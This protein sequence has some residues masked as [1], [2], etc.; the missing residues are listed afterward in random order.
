MEKSGHWGLPYRTAGG[1]SG[2]YCR[3]KRSVFLHL[4]AAR[5]I[6]WKE[7]RSEEPRAWQLSPHSSTSSPSPSLILSTLAQVLEERGHGGRTF[8]RLSSERLLG[9]A[10]SLSFAQRSGDP[11]AFRDSLFTPPQGRRAH[12]AQE[13]ATPAIG[14][15]TDGAVGPA[16]APGGLGEPSLRASRFSRGAALLP[17]KAKLRSRQQREPAACRSR[18]GCDSGNLEAVV[19]RPEALGHTGNTV[20]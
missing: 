6:Q 17:S 2:T 18:S 5:V 15:D 7:A 19:A 12:R 11:S 8:C 14:S 3:G 4:D 16:R 13:R 9:E 1:A 10:M 20:T